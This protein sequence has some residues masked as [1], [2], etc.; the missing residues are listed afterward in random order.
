MSKPK[1]YPRTTPW[2]CRPVFQTGCFTSPGLENRSTTLFLDKF[3]GS[4]SLWRKKRR[5]HLV[6]GMTLPGSLI[7]LDYHVQ[8]FHIIGEFQTGVAMLPG[9]PKDWWV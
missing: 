3:R 8:E 5:H 4:V 1:T 6:Q 2:F 7:R 9:R